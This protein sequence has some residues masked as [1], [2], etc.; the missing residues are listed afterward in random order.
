MSEHTPGPWKPHPE[1][2]TIMPPYNRV[3]TYWPKDGAYQ[4]VADCSHHVTGTPITEGEA[5][6]RLIAA[7]PDLLAALIRME[8]AERKQTNGEEYD[9]SNAILEAR[10]AIF[11]ARGK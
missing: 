11:K 5:N 3:A 8:E 2:C 4:I 1:G 10:A 7:A 6:A 9:F